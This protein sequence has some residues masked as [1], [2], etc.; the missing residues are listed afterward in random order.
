MP[1]YQVQVVLDDVP[2]EGFKRHL[3][4]TQCHDE[5]VIYK[6]I[7][8][9]F[10]VLPR[11]KIF[12]EETASRDQYRCT[13]RVQGEGHI[14]R[15][16]ELEGAV[17]MVQWAVTLAKSGGHLNGRLNVPTGRKHGVRNVHILGEIRRDRGYGRTGWLAY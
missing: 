5:R 2:L 17:E 7:P 15:E 13:G 9:W 6:L 16:R 8:H 12:D 10:H 3:A 11:E 1:T 4:V 14:P